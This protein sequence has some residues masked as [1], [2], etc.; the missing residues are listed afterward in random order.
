MAAARPRRA[1]RPMPRHCAARGRNRRA[2]ATTVGPTPSIRVSSCS[3][4]SSPARA[5]SA[6]SRSLGRVPNAFIRS[7]AVTPPTWR[8]PSP[9]SSRAASGARLASIAANRASTDLACQPSRPSRS[10][11]CVWRRKMSAGSVSQPSSMNSARLFSPS[12]S[13]SSAPRLTKWRSR[14]KRCAGQ[15]RP[16]VQRTSISPS[17]A[18]ASLSALRAMIGEDEGG[19]LLVQRQDS[20]PS[21]G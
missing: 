17:S 15:I 21:A 10:S 1:D 19:P 4:S 9:K 7:R 18:T 16:P 13:M 20:R 11:R 2:R 8:M 6:S 5:A 14:S 12:P 3:A